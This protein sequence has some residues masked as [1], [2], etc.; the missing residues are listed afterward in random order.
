[1]KSFITQIERRFDISSSTSGLIDGSFEIGNL[2]VIV[3]VS[4]F[5]AKLHRPKI[6][7]TGCFIMGLGSI[8]T[9]LPHF[10]MGYYRYSKDTFLNPL[11]NSTSS[12]ST[13]SINQNLLLNRTSPEMVG[14]GWEKESGSY[15]WIYV[16]MGNMLRGIGETPI[17][18]LGI[19]YLD[20]FAEEGHSSFYL[21]NLYAVAMIGPILGFTLG[22]LFSQMYVDIGFVDLST[23][24]ITPKD[25]RWVGA[26]WLGF[27]VAGLVSIISSIPF[28]FLPRNLDKP[29][30]ERKASVSLPVQK[31]E[32]S[33]MANLSKARQDV[34]ETV[35]GFIQ[36][37]KSIL[38]NPLYIIILFL[39]LLQAS[40]FIGSFTYFFKYV[41]QQYGQSASET[42]FLFGFL[43]IPTFAT[44][45]F[46]GGYIIRKFKFTLVGVAKLSFYTS[47]LAFLFH[48]LNFALICENKSVAGI[49]LTY[50]G[51]N[52]LASH[53]N[54]PLSY[55]NSDCNCDES[56]WEP[57]CADNGITY[58]SP[59]LAGC[60]SSSG[61]EKSMVFHNCSCVELNDFQNRNNSVK[62][63]ECP[64][65]DQCRRK[66]YIYIVAQMLHFFSSSL[67]ATSNIMLVFKNVHPELK[68]LAVGFHSLTIRTL[69]GIPAPIYFGAL[70]DRACVRWSINKSGKQGSCRLYSSTLYGK[71]YLGL[72]SSLK[73]PALVLFVVLIYAMKKKYRGKDTKASENEIKAMNE[74]N[75]EPL[76]GDEGPG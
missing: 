52:P 72:S 10:F 69:G 57:V 39:T 71:T 42:S 12:L 19:S 41:E 23:I 43:T 38:T 13:C 33:Q 21:G 24:R 5:G 15:M 64:R 6:I 51:N 66:F 4:Y 20:D 61:S 32:R 9:A 16:L 56:Q 46:V 76:R 63:G 35:N 60:K 45:M 44:G 65:N 74:A 73:F 62:L 3:F 58:L 49:T 67:G 40:S 18:P 22:S 37:L 68:S 50:D 59:C 14:K 29:Q 11:K 34:T 48:L 8:L 7:G 26:W 17:T 36:S 25:S 47:I 31:E 2:L 75:L 30:K 1:M 54:V 55:C 28:F 70:I 27:L 53:I